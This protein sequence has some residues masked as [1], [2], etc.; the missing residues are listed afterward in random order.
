MSWLTA[1]AI[2]S[3]D[4]IGSQDCFRVKVEENNCPGNAKYF[5]LLL[6]I[7]GYTVAP[8]EVPAEYS[9]TVYIQVRDRAQD[10]EVLLSRGEITGPKWNVEESYRILSVYSDNYVDGQIDLT[11]ENDLFPTDVIL[12]ARWIGSVYDSNLASIQPQPLEIDDKNILK[13][14]MA[15]NGEILAKVSSQIA[16]Y[17]ITIPP[18]DMEVVDKFRASLIVSV[19][20]CGQKPYRYGIE[21]PGCLSGGETKIINP[22][23]DFVEPKDKVRSWCL[24]G[25]HEST[26]EPGLF[27]PGVKDPA[28]KTDKCVPEGNDGDYC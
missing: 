24:C 15:I 11:K 1:S 16:E 4:D 13:S 19:P 27:Y 7:M 12:S 22:P 8:A 17:D 23:P 2:I 10:I 5:N 3:A 28:L 14:D 6:S 9:G 21:S 26:T 20:T 18:V 25:N